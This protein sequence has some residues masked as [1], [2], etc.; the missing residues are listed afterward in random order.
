MS[1]NS[2][3]DDNPKSA[4]GVAKAPLHLIPPPALLELARAMQH[5]AEKYGAY[6]WRSHTVSASVYQAAAMRHLLAFWQRENVDRDSAAHHLAHAMACCAIALDAIHAGNFND[7]RPA[8]G[9]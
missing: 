6:N 4:S 7:D 5:G 9:K 3:P 8:T 2:P 1:L